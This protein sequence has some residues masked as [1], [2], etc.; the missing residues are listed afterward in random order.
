MTQSFPLLL[1]S[2][3]GATVAA[4]SESADLASAQA[5]FGAGRFPEAQQAFE[6]I[7]AADS[8]NADAH[9]YLGQ[10]AMGRED[11]Q[12]AIHELERAVALA[13]G[14]ALDHSS[15]GIA[16]GKAAEKA[17]IFD[18][19]GLARRCVAQFERAVE[20]NP[21]NV[22]FRELLFKYYSRAPSIVGGSAKKAADQA[23]AIE[24]IDR[25]LGQLSFA[26]LYIADGK[27]DLALAELDEVLKTDPADYDSL[28]LV[29]RLAAASGQH[30]DRGLAALRLCLKYPVPKGA[31]S[32]SAVQWSLGNIL[33]KEGRPDSA[34]IAY[35][36][37][38]EIDP[39]FSPAAEALRNLR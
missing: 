22:E 5:L 18:R 27:F 28:Y 29:G 36:A 14:N 23:A 34:R 21:G 31:P 10:L 9:Y 11:T 7:A 12:T 26:A 35:E 1:L 30:I 33:E 32:H 38:L 16:Y 3:V 20:L 6:R 25:R 4:A 17:G 13:P 37:A 39:N 24:E 8:A 15:L 19:F 2:L